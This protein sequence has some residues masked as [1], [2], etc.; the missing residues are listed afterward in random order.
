[1]HM[2]DEQTHDTDFDV[3]GWNLNFGQD[4]AWS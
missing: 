2:Q 3:R 4:F 1:M